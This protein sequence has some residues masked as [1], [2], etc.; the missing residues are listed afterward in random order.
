[1]LTEI[2]VSSPIKAI[3]GLRLKVL[4]SSCACLEAC[5]HGGVLSGFGFVSRS[6]RF[7]G[8][9]WK[10]GSSSSVQDVSGRP[11]LPLG[12]CTNFWDVLKVCRIRMMALKQTYDRFM[13][14]NFC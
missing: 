7:A 12:G 6:V 5:S 2:S 11:I 9:S 3:L 13:M 10:S 8:K 4:Q 1:M 14:W